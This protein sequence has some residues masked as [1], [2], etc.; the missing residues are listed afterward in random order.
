MPRVHQ[1]AV[2]EAQL[3]G[4]VSRKERALRDSPGI[5]ATDFETIEHEPQLRLPSF[6]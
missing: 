6:G 3:D 1:E 4:G 2:A 5:S